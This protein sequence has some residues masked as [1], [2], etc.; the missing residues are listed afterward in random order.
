MKGGNKLQTCRIHLTACLTLPNITQ[1]KP[2]QMNGV[3]VKMGMLVC[4]LVPPSLQMNLNG[5]EEGKKFR[6]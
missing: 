6:I 5:M 4:V 1:P 3:W 2:S